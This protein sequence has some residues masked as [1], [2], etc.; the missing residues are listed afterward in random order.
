MIYNVYYVGD[1]MDDD[2]GVGSQCCG[3]CA[4]VIGMVDA[5]LLIP[6]LSVHHMLEPY[7]H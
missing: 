2:V 1:S 3:L 7:A 6:R 5:L 4:R